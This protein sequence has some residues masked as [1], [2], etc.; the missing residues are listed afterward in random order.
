M[1]GVVLVGDFGPSATVWPD[2]LDL[3]SEVPPFSLSTLREMSV[4]Y[5]NVSGFLY[6]LVT[7]SGDK[8]S[9]FGD[10][11]KSVDIFVYLTSRGLLAEDLRF[12]LFG[13]AMTHGHLSL[14]QVLARGLRMPIH[15]TSRLLKCAL[16]RR[17]TEV[18]KWF[19]DS[20][21]VVREHLFMGSFFEECVKS[22]DVLFCQWV[23]DK[24]KITDQCIH[25]H[26]SQIV[27]MAVSNGMLEMC[28]WLVISFGL[29]KNFMRESIVDAAGSGQVIVCRWLLKHFKYDQSDQNFG[30]WLLRQA[31]MGDN[32]NMCRWLSNYFV[33][34]RDH[35][36][37]KIVLNVAATY[38]QPNVCRWLVNHF[39]LTM[40]DMT[41]M[42]DGGVWMMSNS[43]E[44]PNNQSQGAGKQSSRD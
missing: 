16:E 32:V 20:F 22:G 39:G 43:G 24:F 31:V 11:N 37:D 41:T 6:K 25:Q 40:Q 13:A 17:H 34:T 9:N 12:D 14:C 7:P 8:I 23:K 38:K 10:K 3:A 36:D 42:S 5:T 19:L 27:F 1:Q 21:G 28:Q 2:I 4:E 15:R 44:R 26:I 29:P 18:V 30:V 33:L 35:M